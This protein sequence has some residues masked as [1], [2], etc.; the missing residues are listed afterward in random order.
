MDKIQDFLDMHGEKG[1]SVIENVFF[2]LNSSIINSKS[3]NEAEKIKLII[4]S[5]EVLDE[6]KKR[7]K[8]NESFGSVGKEMYNIG[9]RNSGNPSRL[10]RILSRL[11]N[12]KQTVN[13]NVNK[14]G[15]SAERAA[16]SVQKSS[17]MVGRAAI[18]A[19]SAA[20]LALIS[21]AH[22]KF[23]QLVKGRCKN[24]SG[25]E[26][27]MCK[28]ACIEQQIKFLKMHRNSCNRSATPDICKNKVNN[29]IQKLETKK[30]TIFEKISK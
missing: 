6:I 23:E 2:N 18:V 10:S 8:L 16:D 20:G 14:V 29:T 12:A 19:G 13:D 21:A 4:E 11:T 5:N 17:K 24:T 27:K 30:Q 1:F 9:V 22:S 7:Y 15:A 3:F 26:Y 25:K 28:I